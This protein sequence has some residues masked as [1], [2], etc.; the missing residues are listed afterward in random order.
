MIDKY[1]PKR[2][3]FRVTTGG[4]PR[5]E[6]KGEVSTPGSFERRLLAIDGVFRPTPAAVNTPA[7]DN[8]RS[9][10]EHGGVPAVDRNNTGSMLLAVII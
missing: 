4:A 2:F 6:G 8:L 3:V 5:G 1:A 10:S 7:P 9:I